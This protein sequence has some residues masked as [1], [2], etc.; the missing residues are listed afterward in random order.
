MVGVDLDRVLHSFDVDSPLPKPFDHREELFVVD[1][2][3]Q[4][5]RGE[6]AGVVADR[7]QL[8]LGG[9]SVIQ[10]RDTLHHG[11]TGIG[12]GESRP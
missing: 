4:L 12:R 7:M 6:L 3:V 9:R 10:S 1:G 2:V 8:A 5:R 11:L